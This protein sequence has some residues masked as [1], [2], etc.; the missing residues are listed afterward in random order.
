[1]EGGAV[2]SMTPRTAIGLD[3]TQRMSTKKIGHRRV[4]KETG[5]VTYKKVKTSDLMAAIQ[6]GISNAIGSLA[7]APERDLLLQDFEVIERVNFPRYQYQ[8]IRVKPL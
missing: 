5:S 6:L 3:E 2:E 4:D 1:M 7:S 8:M